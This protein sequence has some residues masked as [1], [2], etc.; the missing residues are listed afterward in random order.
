M[1]CSHDDAAQGGLKLVVNCRSDVA[2]ILSNHFL[3]VLAVF[4]FWNLALMFAKRA[5][6]YARKRYATRKVVSEESLLSNRFHAPVLKSKQKYLPT[7]R[8]ILPREFFARV[9]RENKKD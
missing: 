1:I 7:G 2:Y 6:R 4:M 5:I 9:S 8:V 3:G